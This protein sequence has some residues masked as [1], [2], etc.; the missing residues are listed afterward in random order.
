MTRS[1]I[2]LPH[3]P[4]NL[5]YDGPQVAEPFFDVK[6][7]ADHGTITIFDVVGIEVTPGR[8]ANALREIGAKP[9]TLIV[10]SPGGDYFDGI[11][12]YNLLRAHPAPVT[13][14]VIGEAASAA[15]MVVMAADKIQMARNGQLM[16]HNPW[17]LMVGNADDMAAAEKLL[18]QLN[19]ATAETIAERTKL[20][21]GTVSEMLAEETWLSADQALALGF[22]DDLL[23]R[24][25]EPAPATVENSAP[26]SKRDFEAQL[27]RMG[28]A[29]TAAERAAAAGW[30]ALKNDGAPDLTALAETLRAQSLEIRALN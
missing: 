20:P 13:A 23:E 21:V 30:G 17:M 10:N 18:R 9:V 19:V 4:K 28:F 22:A 7:L 15:A 26:K 6:A 3:R 2:P 25:A 27:R 8:V 29:K 24:D 1:Q 14:Q 16:I 11:A 5:R 12:I